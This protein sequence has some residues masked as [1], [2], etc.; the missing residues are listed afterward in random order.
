MTNSTNQN[1]QTK[2][3]K[4]KTVRILKGD[5]VGVKGK[6][7]CEK[8]EKT[9]DYFTVKVKTRQ[10]EVKLTLKENEFEVI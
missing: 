5:W 4:A 1:N 3:T 8:T 7:E 6:L 10:C 2:E 9:G